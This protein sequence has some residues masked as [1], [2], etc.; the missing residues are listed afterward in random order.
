[1]LEDRDDVRQA[2]LKML[3]PVVPKRN[4]TAII[5][6]DQSGLRFE[7]GEVLQFEGSNV[8]IRM[9]SDHDVKTFNVNDVGA[10]MKSE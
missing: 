4:S 3:R 5:L 8:L 7:T 2:T 6:H 1:M 9:Y 10:Y